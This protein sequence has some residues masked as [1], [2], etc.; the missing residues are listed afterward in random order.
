MSNTQDVAAIAQALVNGEPLSTKLYSDG[1]LVVIAPSG[2]K[3]SFTSGEVQAVKQAL[4]PQ[5]EVESGP[6]KVSRTR[7]TPQKGPTQVG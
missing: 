6:K 3:F 1:R 2:Q 5:K 4:Y 7:K